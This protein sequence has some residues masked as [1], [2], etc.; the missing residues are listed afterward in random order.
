[1]VDDAGGVDG[2]DFVDAADVAKAAFQRGRDGVGHGGGIGARAGGENDDGGNI[3]IGQ[4]RDGQ[5]KIRDH[6][7]DEQPKRQQQRCDWPQDERG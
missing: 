4:R 1:M 5:M 6:A 3:E 7:G 2:V